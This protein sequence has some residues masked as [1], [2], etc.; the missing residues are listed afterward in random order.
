M[1]FKVK[2]SLD[3]DDV[4][5][6]MKAV[7]RDGMASTAMGTFTGGIFLTAYALNL[8]ATNFI[9]GLLA[10]I[11]PLMALVQIPSIY[12]VEKIKNRKAI[13]VTTSFAS[14]AF[15][16]LVAGIPFLFSPNIGINVLVLGMALYSIFGAVSGTA[17]GP[18]LRDLLPQDK[19]GDFFSKR[20]IMSTILGIVL[21]F[22]CAVYIDQWKK[23]FPQQ[24]IYGYSIL[25]AL[26]FFAGIIG[27]YYLSTIPEP[28]MSPPE[29]RINFF[30]MLSVP[31]KDGN[32]RKL[33]AFLGSWTFAVNLAGPFF[34]V[35]MIKRLHLPMSLIIGL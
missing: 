19:L 12:L 2:D 10:A 6:G 5:R 18:W 25:F 17:W 4:R 22:V 27:V 21:S 29:G 28:R 33:M 7:I 13:V 14:R 11:G 31:F 20:M 35:Y 26:G 23:L 9:I 8:G 34:A 1:W 15:W 3:E 24:E 16:L 30:G 32:F